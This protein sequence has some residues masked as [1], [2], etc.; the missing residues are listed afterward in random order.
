MPF[1]YLGNGCVT[2]AIPA[3][4]LTRESRLEQSL[5]DQVSFLHFLL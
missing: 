5:L 4:T 1:S 3:E 2:R